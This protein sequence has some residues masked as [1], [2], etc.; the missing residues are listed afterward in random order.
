MQIVISAI[1]T[2]GPSLRQ[3][4][5]DD[6]RLERYLLRLD[7]KQTP[8]REPGWLKLHSAGLRRGA[9]NVVWDGQAHILTARVVTRGATRAS[10]IVGDFINYLLSRHAGRVNAITTAIVR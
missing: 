2:N 5:G 8:G 10:G 6:P 1:C 4:I 9:I 7:K 3:A